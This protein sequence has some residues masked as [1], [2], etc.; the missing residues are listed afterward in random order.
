MIWLSLGSIS[1]LGLGLLLMAH[2]R[3]LA[4]FTLA[5]AVLGAFDAYVTR[6]AI[7]QPLLALAGF[8]LL[9]SPPWALWLGSVLL[10]ADDRGRT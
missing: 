10:R 6:A 8:K 9:L 7:G 4:W 1:W 3:R 2:R 5:L